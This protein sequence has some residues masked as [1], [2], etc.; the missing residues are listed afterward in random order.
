MKTEGGFQ[1]GYRDVIQYMEDHRDSY[2]QRLLTAN[3]VNQPWIFA[4]FYTRTDPRVWASDHRN[5]YRILVPQEYR[6][7]NLD[8][9]TL[10]SLRE[11]ELSYFEDFTVRKEV[12][13]PD[14]E[15]EFVVAEVRQRKDF[16]TH[17]SARGLFRY[18]SPR[19]VARSAPRIELDSSVEWRSMQNQYITLDFNRFYAAEAD[20]NP[21][22]CCAEAVTYVRLQE[23]PFEAQLEVFGSDDP[24]AL[25]I[26]G[27]LVMNHQRLSPRP[28]VEPVTLAPGWNE[29]SIRSC[30]SIGDWF[31]AIRLSD[32]DGKNLAGLQQGD[33]P[34]ESITAWAKRRAQEFA[35]TPG[36]ADTNAFDGAPLVEGFS[37]IV[38]S[39]QRSHDYPGH[40]GNGPSFWAYHRVEK[41]E[42]V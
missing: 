8:E 37:R 1:F 36:A 16:L 20:G 23:D 11:S 34:N 30:E 14:G 38:R 15:V 42:V 9:P 10:Y 18:R 13:A 22:R 33:S 40:R 29:I 2:P 28:S 3:R 24:L 6:L 27:S 17:W 39:N 31:V 26:N 25:W 19:A 5:G 7:Y 21:E 41:Q 4:N 35:A 32:V 12:V